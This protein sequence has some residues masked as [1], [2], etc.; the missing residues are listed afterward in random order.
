MGGEPLTPTR[1]ISLSMLAR[2][3]K[4]QT[5]YS[6]SE[7]SMLQRLP[8]EILLM[9]VS[10][11][12]GP[13]DEGS[14]FAFF[15]LRQVFRRFSRLLQAEDF[16]THPF[17]RKRCCQMCSDGF[18]DKHTSQF[19]LNGPHCFQYTSVR[20]VKVIGGD[21]RTK[22]RWRPG[23]LADFIRRST[24]CKNY[25]DNREARIKAGYPA[26]CKFSHSHSE[27][28]LHCHS[29]DMDHPP[30]CFS[31]DQA[32]LRGGR[33]CIANE[34]CIRI[35]EHKKLTRADIKLLPGGVPDD[36]LVF[37]TSCDRPD[38]KVPCSDNSEYIDQ[39]PSVFVTN[40]GGSGVI[41]NVLWRGH[42]GSDRSILHSSGYLNR[43]Q[44]YDSLR[45]IGQ[46]GGYLLLP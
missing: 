7:P 22:R 46:N 2:L 25:Q 45:K 21:V 41:L 36:G 27:E 1:G 34:G 29:C 28:L 5:S 42:S 40:P 13:R 35:C 17:S 10:Y 30:L 23:R 44:L 15:A 31:E 18:K 3:R 11:I 43:H 8:D 9:I 20:E 12:S 32:K 24:T 6:R 39:T 19:Q 4:D 26:T 38:H 37:V 14:L 16:I 33:V